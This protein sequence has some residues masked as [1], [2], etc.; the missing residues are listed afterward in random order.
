M[1]AE[2][3]TSLIKSTHT[4]SAAERNLQ[5]VVCCV[6]TPRVASPG[7]SGKPR[8]ALGRRPN[9]TIEDIYHLDSWHR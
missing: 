6:K 2:T 9:K 7:T 3:S 5:H 4:F 1:K 8:A